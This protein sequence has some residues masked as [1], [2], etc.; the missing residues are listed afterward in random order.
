MDP[1]ATGEQ[2]TELLIVCAGYIPVLIMAV[3]LGIRLDLRRH[4]RERKEQRAAVV[5]N[6]AIRMQE[7]KERDLVARAAEDQFKRELQAA[8]GADQKLELISRWQREGR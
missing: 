7:A 8:Q 2:M 5:A 3:W 6:W 1:I 4:R